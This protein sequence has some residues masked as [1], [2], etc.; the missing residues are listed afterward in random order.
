M[1]K[2]VLLLSLITFS[3]LAKAQIGVNTPNPLGSFH[4]DGGKDNPTTGTPTSAQQFNDFVLLKNGNLGI[5]TINPS[6]KLEIIV[7]NQGEGVAN[8]FNFRGFGTSK[9]PAL[10]F[11]SSNGTTTTP[12]NLI[13]DDPIGAVT[14]IPR[15]NNGFNYNGGSRITAT[16]QGNGINTFT[17]LRLSTSGNE[18]IRI[19]E[20]GKI[21]INTTTPNNQL[22]LGPTTGSK[23][24]AIYNNSSGSDFYGLG[25][26]GG[27][28]EFHAGV[29]PFE[30]AGMVLRNNKNVGI[31]TTAPQTRL[32]VIGTRR[33]ENATPSSVPIGTVLTATDINGTAEWKNP[34]VNVAFG[35]IA[36]GAG[37]SIPFQNNAS[38]KYTGR[39][40]TLPEG[41]WAINVTQL[42]QTSGDLD[43]DDTMFVRS[44]F[45]EGNPSVGD[46]VTPSPDIKSGYSLVS[47]KVQG[48]ANSSNSQQFSLGQGT[49][50]IK[51]VSGG[52]KTYYYIAGNTV[53]GGNPTAAT[54]VRGFGAGWGESTIYAI[55]VQ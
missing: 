55:A 28:L 35:A 38:Y 8:D 36:P 11:S 5:G 29:G 14:F 23:K 9:L 44:T 24:L 12:V 43:N 49:V 33:F 27:N 13:K 21:G 45:G 17:D 1:K 42:V 39:Y 34:A 3:S 41:K 2:I 53:T 47:F 25:A 15:V 6:S 51:N 37:I 22:D 16:Y 48:P 20:D 46:V 30:M 50:F 26:S 18:R 10:I 54:F 4:V 32:H 7:D 52:P 19:A 31:G 40:I